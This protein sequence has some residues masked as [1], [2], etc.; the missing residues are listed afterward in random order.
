MSFWRLEKGIPSKFEELVLLSIR[1]I[2][3][4]AT[5]TQILRKAEELSPKKRKIRFNKL[6]L[7]LYWLDFLGFVH[8]WSDE[9]E[10]DGRWRHP[11]SRHFRVQLRGERLLDVCEDR[12][13]YSSKT[14]SEST[15][16]HWTS[17]IWSWLSGRPRT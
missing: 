12:R 15:L 11:E 9:P 1:E 2:G 7:T 10:L 5:L 13:K 8:S 3:H 17:A 4:G 14:K 16:P 6:Y